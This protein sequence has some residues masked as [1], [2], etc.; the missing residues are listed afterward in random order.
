MAPGPA[1]PSVRPSSTAAAPYGAVGSA[2]PTE[3]TDPLQA[4][5]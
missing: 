2:E 1:G 4:R 5:A 3:H